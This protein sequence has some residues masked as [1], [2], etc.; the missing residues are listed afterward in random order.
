MI[1]VFGSFVLNGDPTVKQLG[2]GLAVAVALALA[3]GSVLVLTPAIL[4]LLGG[5]AWWM[6]SLLERVVP[7]LDIDGEHLMPH[8]VRDEATGAP[9][10]AALTESAE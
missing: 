1:T 8:V 9:D 6:P 7:N 5:V 10:A 3:A 2:V 4:V